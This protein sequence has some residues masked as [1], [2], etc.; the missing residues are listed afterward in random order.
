M[1]WKGYAIEKIKCP[2]CKVLNEV[3]DDEPYFVC[4]ACGKKCTNTVFLPLDLG[5]DPE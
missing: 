2:H 5:C 4:T 3:R 1:T